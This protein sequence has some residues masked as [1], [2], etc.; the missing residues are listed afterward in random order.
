[1]K[2][3]SNFYDVTFVYVSI[4]YFVSHILF[5][6]SSVLIE[7]DFPDVIVRKRLSPLQYFIQIFQR[8]EKFTLFLNFF[9][10]DNIHY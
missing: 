8:I 3:E 4:L 6:S 5:L 7:V 9:E 2:R 10:W 1:M